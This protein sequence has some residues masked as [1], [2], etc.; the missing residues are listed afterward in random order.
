VKQ[1]DIQVLGAASYSAPLLST[2]ILCLAGYATF[3]PVLG[4]ACLLITLGAVVAASELLFRRRAGTATRRSPEGLVPWAGRARHGTD[5]PDFDPRSGCGGE[6]AQQA[7]R[8]A[9]L[10]TSITLHACNLPHAEDQLR[11]MD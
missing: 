4:I 1:G 2:S 11:E 8:P 3:T 7:D 6:P 9:T 5:Q 10:R